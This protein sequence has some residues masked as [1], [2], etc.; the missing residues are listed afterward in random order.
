[1]HPEP[2]TDETLWLYLDGE[3]DP[4]D[5]AQL[6]ARL[7]SDPD[8]AVRLESFRRFTGAVETAL[9][10]RVASIPA[11]ALWERVSAELDAAPPLP[12]PVPVAAPARVGLMERLRRFFAMPPL[13]F[14][15]TATAAVAAIAVS[16]W[17]LRSGPTRPAAPPEAVAEAPDNTFVIESY[18]V[19]EGTVVID[20]QED[21]PSAPAVVWHFVDDAD[22]PSPTQG[23]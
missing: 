11:G 21:D 9:D 10:A 16:V 13:E 2:V 17:T 5:V 20:V 6:E 4:D 7:A 15:L 12:S 8:T 18:E 23:G 3:L 14:G 1:M 22:Q 19:T